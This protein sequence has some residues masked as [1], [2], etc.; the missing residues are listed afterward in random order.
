MKRHGILGFWDSY[1]LGASSGPKYPKYLGVI[2]HG[3]NS[4]SKIEYKHVMLGTCWEYTIPRSHETLRADKVE[5]LWTRAVLTMTNNL[6]MPMH[7]SRFHQDLNQRL[8]YGLLGR[9]NCDLFQTVLERFLPCDLQLQKF[10]LGDLLSKHLVFLGP[11]LATLPVAVPIAYRVYTLGVHLN[12]SRL[13]LRC[14][15]SSSLL[16]T[17]CFT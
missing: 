14:E 9:R 12:I 13:V 5:H 6:Q 4:Y 15:L 8:Q 1:D 2:L 10:P 17:N 11:T 3:T 7:S 16:G